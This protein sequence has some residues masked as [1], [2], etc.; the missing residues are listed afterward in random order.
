MKRV[1][2]KQFCLVL[3]IALVAASVLPAFAYTSKKAYVVK[4]LDGRDRLNVHG[5]PGIGNVIDHLDVGTVVL[6]ESSDDGW[7]Y[8]QW[9]KANGSFGNGY[10]DGKYLA[11]VDADSA[12]K[13]TCVDNLYVHSQCDIVL[14][15]CS[16]Y[17]IGQLM[18][19]AKMT[20]LKQEGTWAYVSSGNLKGWVSSIYLVKAD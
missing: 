10:V 9:R 2:L 7:W 17:H 15:E 3:L 16:K 4:P 11:A 18:K 20:V 1:A 19:G 12:V 14:G 5:T 13:F 8:V 6:Y